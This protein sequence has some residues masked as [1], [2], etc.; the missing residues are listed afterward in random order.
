MQYNQTPEEFFEQWAE[1]QPQATLAERFV[2]AVTENSAIAREVFGSVEGGETKFAQ[3]IKE[4]T[5]NPEAE[6]LIAQYLE[7]YLDTV[8]EINRQEV[9]RLCRNG[10]EDEMKLRAA[11]DVGD[12]IQDLQARFEI[13]MEDSE[14]PMLIESSDDEDYTGLPELIDSSG[15]E[16]EEIHYA[17]AAA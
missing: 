4:M 2:S 11:R 12:E 10:V 1:E 15:D 3:E 9:D 17:A 16:E 14:L 13:A 7:D 5:N 6:T 8:A